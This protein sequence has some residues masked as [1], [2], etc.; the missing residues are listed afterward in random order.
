MAQAWPQGRPKFFTTRGAFSGHAQVFSPQEDFY[1]RKGFSPGRAE[2]FF[3]KVGGPLQGMLKFFFATCFFRKNKSEQV[4]TLTGSPVCIRQCM[5]AFDAAIRQ[6]LCDPKQRRY[7]R[8]IG[9]P[10]YVFWGR[11]AMGFM[12]TRCANGTFWDKPFASK[13]ADSLGRFWA[14][15]KQNHWAIVLLTTRNSKQPTM[16]NPAFR[17]VVFPKRASAGTGKRWS[18]RYMRCKKCRL[19]GDAFSVP[20]TTAATPASGQSI[21]LLNNIDNIIYFKKLILFC[22]LKTV[23]KTLKSLMR[24]ALKILVCDFGQNDTS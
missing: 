8:A 21:S 16:A 19:R 18:E 24:R 11:L 15:L 4:T 1:L 22:Q 6:I 3:A 9:W 2:R 5:T 17:A 20:A 13:F 12:T 7:V 10:V 14:L 23:E